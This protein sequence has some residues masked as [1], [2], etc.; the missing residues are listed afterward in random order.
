VVAI[1]AA[2]DAAAAVA[3]AAARLSMKRPPMARQLLQHRRSPRAAK[4]KPPALKLVSAVGRCPNSWQRAPRIGHCGDGDNEANRPG[5][6]R[7]ATRP[8]FLA[9]FTLLAI[10]FRLD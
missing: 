4:A 5:H 1:V 10:V 6:S 8:C 2:V 9:A 3:V 7:R